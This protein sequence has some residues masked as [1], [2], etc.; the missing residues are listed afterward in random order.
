MIDK[1]SQ[2]SLL[3]RI[4]ILPLLNH[5]EIEMF[6]PLLIVFMHSLSEHVLLN[7]FPD[8]FVDE[9]VFR[10]IDVCADA[11]SLAGCENDVY[12]GVF[13]ALEPLISTAC[14][15]R[16]FFVGALH[17]GSKVDAVVVAA[18]QVYAIFYNL[19]KMWTLEGDYLI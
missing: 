2:S 14:T 15:A 9:G 19:S 10:D 16:T 1:S 13:A 8:I 5:H 6:D 4:N 7:H 12:G 17:G 3:C 18:G 11:V